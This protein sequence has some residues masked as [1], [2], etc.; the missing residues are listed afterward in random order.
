MVYYRPEAQTLMAYYRLYPSAFAKMFAMLS[1]GGPGPG[2]LGVSIMKLITTV[3]AYMVIS[4]EVIF[5]REN[6]P[7]LAHLRKTD[8][9]VQL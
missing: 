4:P 2:Y 6:P 3:R 7:L 5:G 8:P 9:Y 1:T